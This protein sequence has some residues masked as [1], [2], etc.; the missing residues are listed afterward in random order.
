MRNVRVV[1]LGLASFMSAFAVAAP[2]HAGLRAQADT[3]TPSPG[4][5]R[6]TG[7]VKIAEPKLKVV[8]QAFEI[9]L[10][11]VKKNYDEPLYQALRKLP[12]ET[13]VATL[14]AR[15]YIQIGTPQL[16]DMLKKIQDEKKAETDRPNKD[17]KWLALLDRVLWAAPLATK[18]G[19][20]KDSKPE[21]NK[22]FEDAFAKADA[23]RNKFNED[24]AKAGTNEKAKEAVI[25]AANRDLVPAFLGAQAKHGGEA[26]VGALANVFG[27][28]GGKGQKFL[29]LIGGENAEAQRL[30]LGT[31]PAE[32]VNSLKVA[33]AH[34]D[35]F[36]NVAWYP[37]QHDAPAKSWFVQGN[38]WKVGVP[39]GGA[40][41]V[42]VK[43]PVAST[44]PPARGGA[45]SPPPPS[46][47]PPP[48]GGGPLAAVKATI[49]SATCTGCHG[50]SA[51]PL[52]LEGDKLKGRPVKEVL[53]SGAGKTGVMPPA[54]IAAI[55]DLLKTL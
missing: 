34:L 27:L 11:V 9:P 18:D 48:A 49:E 4:G 2:S 36:E 33:S 17:E 55:K 30:Y 37:K 6:R 16:P 13:E 32:Y 44:P 40:P 41:P 47:P 39:D 26:L 28:N 21:F 5:E 29:E 7:E 1:V 20:A 45:G 12:D 8:S 23:R 25:A 19:P 24:L 54:A 46:A 14:I 35:N 52:K 10:R 15:W 50:K 53:A 31:N 3:A 51:S 43:S 42:P 38:E 22:A